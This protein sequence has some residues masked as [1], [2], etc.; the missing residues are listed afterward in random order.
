MA[1]VG[2]AQPSISSWPARSAPRP[3]V[4][5]PIRGPARDRHPHPSRPRPALRRAAGRRTPGAA[6]RDRPVRRA[7]DDRPARRDG[8]LVGDRHGGPRRG[9][10]RSPRSRW[11]TSSRASRSRRARRPGCG[12]AAE[13]ACRLSNAS[14]PAV[15]AE[16]LGDWLLRASGGF[17]A[18]ANSVMAIGDPGVPLPEALARRTRVLRRARPARVGPGRRRIAP[19]GAARGGRVDAT[20]GPARPTPSFQLASVAQAARAVRRTRPAVRTGRR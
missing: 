8:V 1:P 4:E 15:H 10:H 14:W 18:R 5:S 20:P 2:P 9:R 17:S 6:R 12:C 19:A 11:P 7:R 13:Q 16:P 3:P